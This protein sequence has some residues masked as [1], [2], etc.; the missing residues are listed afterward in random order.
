MGCAYG[1][2]DR[3]EEGCERC[4][5]SSSSRLERPSRQ[6]PSFP[7][8]PLS[9]HDAKNCSQ[10]S[11]QL[12]FIMGYRKKWEN[13]KHLD[14][15]QYWSEICEMSE[16]R[17]RIE[18][19]ILQQTIVSAGAGAGASGVAGFFTLGAAWTL[20]A[21]NARRINVNSRQ[22]DMVER[23]LAEMGWSGHDMRSAP[24]YDE[25]DPN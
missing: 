6:V 1:A 9:S 24:T 21:V 2:P 7:V 12:L 3:N 13:F 5:K 4:Y 20:T 10:T 17:L 14:E 19:K 15:G 23:R 16:D 11:L 25:C 18:H 22:C 8:L